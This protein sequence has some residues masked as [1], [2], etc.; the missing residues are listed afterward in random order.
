MIGFDE[1]PTGVVQSAGEYLLT[2]DEMVEF[3]RKWDPQ[4]FHIDPEAARATQ[5]GRVTASAAH[6]FCI[7]SALFNRLEPM[8]LICGLKNEFTMLQPVYADYRLTLSIAC[9][10]KRLSQSKPDR[11]IAR[12]VYHLN[13]Q[14]GKEVAEGAVSFLIARQT[15]GG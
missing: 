4:P 13:N 1:I 3:A 6:V 2:Q 8:A 14:E 11:G 12:F 9:E 10:E 7:V 15:P 5:F